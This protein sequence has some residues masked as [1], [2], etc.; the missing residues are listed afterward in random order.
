MHGSW[1]NLVALLESGR[2]EFQSMEEMRRRARVERTFQRT[3]SHG[4]RATVSG[5]STS[6]TYNDQN[7]R[8]DRSS[9]IS[10]SPDISSRHLRAKEDT[11]SNSSSA[12]ISG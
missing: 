12:L 8:T 1:K 10:T 11:L 7:D 3:G 2:T 5:A 9:A 4:S 6:R